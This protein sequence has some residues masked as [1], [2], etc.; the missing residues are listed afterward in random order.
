MAAQNASVYLKRYFDSFFYFSF[1]F[2]PVAFSRKRYDYT[3]SITAKVVA[4]VYQLINWQ[5][6]HTIR[7]KKMIYEIEIA[8]R[9]I[10]KEGFGSFLKKIS[11][12]FIQ[13]F[14]GVRFLLTPLPKNGGPEELVDFSFRAASGFLQTTQI[15]AEIVQLT[16]LVGKRK[17]KVVVEI[18]TAHGGTLFLWCRQAHS[19][20]TIISIDLP[21]G[22]H[23]GG[24]PYWKSWIYRRFLLNGQKLYLLRGD[25]H[26]TEMLERLKKLLLGKVMVD[27][28]FIDA[29]H[30]YEGI[31]TDFQMYSSL[32]CPGGLIALHDIVK[33]PDWLNCHVDRFWQEIKNERRIHEFVNDSNQSFGGIGVV[34]VPEQINHEDSVPQ[35]S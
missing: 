3:N 31:K 19:E 9:T 16:K 34:E 27:F 15:R 10:R 18:G 35:I 24:Y 12:Y 6:R 11:A 20:A 33:H 23:G 25:S 17:P 26:K 14:R 21:G 13:I 4:Q 29:D 2:K 7:I 28:L 22:I 5:Q 32:V 30:T 8:L 1:F